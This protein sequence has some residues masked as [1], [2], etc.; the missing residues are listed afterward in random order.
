MLNYSAKESLIQSMREH[1]GI[2]LLKVM[3]TKPINGQLV[4]FKTRSV[5]DEVNLKLIAF[6]GIT[7]K[8]VR[9]YRKDEANRPADAKQITLVIVI[10]ETIIKSFYSCYAVTMPEPEKL[11]PVNGLIVVPDGKKTIEIK[12]GKAKKEPEKMVSLSE[13]AGKVSAPD[14][15]E[16]VKT[17]DESEIITLTLSK[18][19]FDRYMSFKTNVSK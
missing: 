16:P 2:D 10:N 1:T 14:K 13:L 9:L 15:V 19:E 12:P 18:D 3:E 5:S 17:A 11:Q 7:G 8:K 4:T 6:Q